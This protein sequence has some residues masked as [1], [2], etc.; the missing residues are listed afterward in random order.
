[1]QQSTALYDPIRSATPSQRLAAAAHR[2][3]QANIEANAIGE[4]AARVISFEIPNTPFGVAK[5]R[6]RDRTPTSPE[7]A[8]IHRMW[9]EDL[10]IEA[11]RHLKKTT[12]RDVLRATAFHFG[13]SVAELTKGGRTKPL[14]F[15]RH[16]AMYIATAVTDHSLP[17]IGRRFGGYDHSSI[18]HGRNR[19]RYLLPKDAEIAAHVNAI[20]RSIPGAKVLHV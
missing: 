11:E 7:P 10:I 9:F 15:C 8:P 16:I 2:M 1:M 4:R 12:V 13:V 3:R 5:I 17:E 19:I 20:I 6:E 18:L 14:V